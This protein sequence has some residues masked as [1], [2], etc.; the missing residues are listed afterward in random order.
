MSQPQFMVRK[1]ATRTLAIKTKRQAG[2]KQARCQTKKYASEHWKCSDTDTVTAWQRRN[3]ILSSEKIEELLKLRRR[4]KVKTKPFRCRLPKRC[5]ATDWWRHCVYVR[6]CL[7]VCDCVFWLESVFVVAVLCVNVVTV[8]M[9]RKSL[10]PFP[11]C[12]T[13]T[14]TN[15]LSNKN[16]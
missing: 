1:S 12:V 8:A 2:A 9:R 6:V 7:S 10:L 3:S 11:F 14:D 15:T 5:T 16:N 4:K 13:L